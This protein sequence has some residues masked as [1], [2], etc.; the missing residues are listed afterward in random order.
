MRNDV[1]FHDFVIILCDVFLYDVWLNC[2]VLRRMFGFRLFVEMFYC[3]Y[4]SNDK[5]DLIK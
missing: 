1:F 4:D 2:I 3:V 5:I